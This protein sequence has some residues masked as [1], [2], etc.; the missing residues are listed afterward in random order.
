[1][2]F[3]ELQYVDPDVYITENSIVLCQGIF[4]NDLFKVL[5]LLPPPLHHKKN[6][7]YKLNECD[8][9]GSYFKKQRLIA[10]SHLQK[11]KI[12]SLPGSKTKDAAMK[13]E[14]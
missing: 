1:M 2:T 7:I 9:F 12:Q 8:Y 14:N 3:S 13:D 5:Q 4:D 6:F 10:E 11:A